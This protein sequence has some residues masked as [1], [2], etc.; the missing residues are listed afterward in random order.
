M[1]P[2]RDHV[3]KERNMPSDA[4]VSATGNRTITIKGLSFQYQERYRVTDGAFQR[5]GDDGNWVALDPAELPTLCERV[6]QDMAENV[7][8]LFAIK[9]NKVLPEGAADASGLDAAT[10]A[11]LRDDFAE[12]V[13]EYTF[14]GSK[15]PRGPRDALKDYTLGMMFT[16]LSA[17]TAKAGQ[18]FS[19][20]AMTKRCLDIYNE[21]PEKWREKGAAMQ[22]REKA[23]AELT[24]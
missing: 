18:T 11:S 15:G 24:M 16:Q 17:A 23:D 19:R 20:A 8:N 14:G 10:V 1:V 5:R 13:D 4:V 12:L 6:N 2:D 3:T 9:V 22:K 21:N 7:R